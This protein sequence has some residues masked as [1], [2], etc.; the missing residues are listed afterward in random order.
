MRRLKWYQRWAV[1]R[2]LQVLAVVFGALPRVEV[3]ETMCD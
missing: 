2:P 3:D 1:E